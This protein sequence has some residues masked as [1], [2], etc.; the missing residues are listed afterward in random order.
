[1]PHPFF[2]S[3]ATSRPLILGHRG[4]AGTTPE[5]TL[6]SF[7]QGLRDGADVLE[8]DVHLT[9][10]GVPVLLHDASVDRTTEATGLV[11][12]LTLAEIRELDA[13]HRFS[14][15]GSHDFPYRN[16]GVT[17]PTLEQAFRRF[18]TAR[19]NLELKTGGAAVAERVVELVQQLDREDRTLL[20]AG[21]D[22]LMDQLVAA[23][24]AR[25]A[26]PAFG[27]CTRDAAGF[28]RSAAD[29]TPPPPTPMAL[30]IPAEFGGQPL[31]TPELVQ[32]AHTHGVQ[33][34][35]W[36]I[37]EPDEMTRLLDLGVDGLVTDFPA[38]MRDLLERRHHAET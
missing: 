3:P 23:A 17:I 34:H 6:T 18:P 28:A 7:E 37:N 15:D 22:D 10:D 36:T 14:P 2:E 8:S 31:I 9:R 19:F 29:A 25:N 27:A 20:T 38:R 12:S 33:V 24:H 13:A 5:N 21:E 30:Q 35:A 11:A 32:H 4:A 16:K 26:S 1:M